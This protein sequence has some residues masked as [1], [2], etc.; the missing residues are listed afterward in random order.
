MSALATRRLGKDGPNVTALGYGLMGLSAFY[1]PVKPDSE[2]F[3]VLDKLYELGVHFWD[4]GEYRVHQ[5]NFSTGML[6]SFGLQR[7]YTRTAKICSADGSPRAR[8]NARRSF[9]RRSSAPSALRMRKRRSR[10]LPPARIHRTTTAK[11]PA[12]G[13]YGVWACRTS[14]CTTA[15]V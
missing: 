3:A 13:V 15:I 1:G 6:I 2:R 10:T 4:S 9:S 7:I 11:K 14:T 8:E 5:S 12:T